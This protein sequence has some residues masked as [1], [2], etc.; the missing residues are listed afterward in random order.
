MRK[1]YSIALVVISFI[2]VLLATF[3][4]P[5]ISSALCTLLKADSGFCATNI[6]KSSESLM[7]ASSIT[8]E[9]SLSEG[10]DNLQARTTKQINPELEQQ[11]LQIIRNNP[12]VIIESVQ[13]YQ[14]QQQKQKQQARQAFLQDFKNNPGKIIA[15]SPTTGAADARIILIEFS[16]FQCP[17]CAKAHKTVKQFMAK[18]QN[19][20]MW[21]YKHLPLASIHP[22]AIPAAQASWAAYQQGKFWEYHD[23]LFEEQDKLGE[24]LYLDIARSLNLDIKKFNRDRQLA[25]PAI[26][27]DLA[28]AR[29]LGISGTPFFVM[30]QETFG[31]AV[32]LS[33]LEEILARVR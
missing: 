20:V 31:G 17:F 21:V 22:Q 13:A 32:S 26:E 10:D 29:Q 4:L 1:I 11:V 24:K 18:H 14:Q 8:K 7:V 19:E 6:A 23:A 3:S 12:E 25:L 16:D 30:N 15:S 27:Q 2:A 28:L 9:K 33:D 5:S